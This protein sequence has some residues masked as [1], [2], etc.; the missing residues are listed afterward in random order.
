MNQL[1][2]LKTLIIAEEFGYE[3]K[4]VLKYQRTK[5]TDN[6]SITIKHQI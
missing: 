2:L 5:D 3:V 6:L 4:T 1:S